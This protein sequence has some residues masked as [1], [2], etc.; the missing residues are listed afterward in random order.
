MRHILLQ[1]FARTPLP[2]DCVNVFLC[3]YAIWLHVCYIG[4]FSTGFLV[5]SSF[6]PLRGGSLWKQS[7]T[8]ATESRRTNS[9]SVTSHT[10]EATDQ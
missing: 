1:M 8:I 7:A 6:F 3:A 5:H 4:F 9:D 2:Y 10:S